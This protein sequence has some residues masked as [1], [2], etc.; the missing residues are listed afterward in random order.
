MYTKTFADGKVKI[1]IEL[2]DRE[3][4][5]DKVISKILFLSILTNL[6][7]FNV[8]RGNVRDELEPFRVPKP[9]EFTMELEEENIDDDNVSLNNGRVL[10][11]RKERQFQKEIKV[12]SCDI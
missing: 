7:F 12:E 9:Y 10:V 11:R 6:V 2:I 8:T 4:L 3:A 5:N 1:N